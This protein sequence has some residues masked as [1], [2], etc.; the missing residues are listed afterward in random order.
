MIA[1]G[2]VAKLGFVWNLADLFMG[3]MTII[4]I[5]AIIR[6]GKIAKLCLDDYLS[7]K[8]QGKD[9]VFKAENIGLTEHVDCWK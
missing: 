9:P 7:Q 3:L 4:N 5:Y 6:L 2:S 8:A 1:F